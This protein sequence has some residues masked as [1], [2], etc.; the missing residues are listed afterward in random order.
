MLAKDITKET[1]LEN[2]KIISQAFQPAKV[3]EKLNSHLI[4]LVKKE[5]L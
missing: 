3:A 1:L 5:T 2:K 4:S